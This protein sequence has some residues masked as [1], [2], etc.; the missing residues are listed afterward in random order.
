MELG[1]FT[2]ILANGIFAICSVIAIKIF[3]SSFTPTPK[4]SANGNS[5]KESKTNINP[6]IMQIATS[7]EEI[8][9][10]SQN[11]IEILLK[12]TTIIGMIT[13]CADIVITSISNIVFNILFFL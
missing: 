1:V 10:E 5:I 11:S 3:N 7:G 2:E 4:N 12:L 6:P 8:T 9:F 13:N